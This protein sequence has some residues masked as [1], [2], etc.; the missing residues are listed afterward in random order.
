MTEPRARRV[1]PTAACLAVMAAGASAQTPQHQHYEKPPAE[2][3]RPAPSGAVAPRLQNLGD[4]AFPVTTRSRQA[5]LF[6]NQGLRLAYGFNHAEA[7]RSFREAARLDPECAMAY[8]GQALVLGPNINMPME[9]QAEPQALE[10]MKQAQAR[11]ARVTARERG[12]IDALAKRYTGQA[13]DRAAADKAYAE[14]M[15]AL[16][17]RYPADLDAAALHAESV[18]TLSPWSYWTR[19]GRP[20]PGTEE[21]RR[22]LEAV[23]AK[24]PRHPMALHLYIHLMEPTRHVARAEAAADRLLELMPGAGHMVHMPSH[25]YYR[26]GRYADASRSNEKAIL[27]DEDYIT[28]CRA[29]GVYPLGYYPHNI[30]FLWAAATMEGRSQAALQAAVK[31]AAKVPREAVRDVPILQAF[32]VVPH[33]A[34]VRFGEWGKVLAEAQ[35]PWDSAFSRGLWHWARGVA[36]VR[37]GRLAEAQVELDR[38]QAALAD[39]ALPG[40]PATFSYNTPDGILRIAPEHLAGELRLAQERTDEGLAHLERAVKWEDALVYTEPPDWAFPARHALGAA[41]LK[42]GRPAEAEVVLWEDLQRNPGNGW[43]LFGL[44]QAQRAQGKDA[45]EAEARFREAWKAADFELKGVVF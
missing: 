13:S 26:I 24:S 21:V 16:A 18:M 45:A 39:P 6:V 33:F 7:G 30:H 38:L 40:S 32:L 15:G 23:M 22:A 2:A 31:T 35:A 37:K 17:K 10:L 8:W 42:A 25:I 1:M 12:Y 44:A 4:H 5:Q 29:Q 36:L 9:A 27:A 43:A 11:R 14:A 34:W 3:S 28:Q 20:R 41:L 19:D